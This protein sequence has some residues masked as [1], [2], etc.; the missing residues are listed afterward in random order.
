MPASSSHRRV[1]LVLLFV[2]L[3]LI[4][5]NM[6][7]PITGVGPLLEQISASTGRSLSVLSLMT[8]LPVLSWAIVSSLAHPL[9]RRFGMRRVVLV[10]LIVLAIGSIARS[11]PGVAAEVS[12][13]TGTVLIGAA[14]AILNVLLPAIVKRSFGARTTLVT[15]AYSA[16]LA[17]C[18]A[19]TSSLVVPISHA[20]SGGEGATGWRVALVA[21]TVTLPFAIAAWVWHL[22]QVGPEVPVPPRAADAPRERSVWGDRT[23][24]LI[25]GYMGT[26]STM[27]YAML[28]WTAPFSRSHGFSEVTAGNHTMLFQILG[29]AG[30]VLLPFAMRGRLERWMPALVPVFGL[31]GTTGLMLFPQWINVWLVAQGLTSGAALTLTLALMAS[32][33]RDHHTASALSGMS[34]SVGYVIAGMAPLVFGW[35][36][37]LTGGWTASFGYVIAILLTQLTLGLFVGRGRRVFD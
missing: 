3:C 31:I 37:T 32:R 22:R 7:S 21:A 28:T 4:A 23:A 17:G 12:M 11:L 13:W 20:V 16:L 10:A 33:A 29:V 36:H 14:I 2:A 27:F 15:G 9:T 8:S 30:S 19:I 35:L 18:G 24:W 5:V 6:R 1:S 34:Q 26:Q 25:G